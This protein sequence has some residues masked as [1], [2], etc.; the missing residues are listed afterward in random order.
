MKIRGRWLILTGVMAAV[1]IFAAFGLNR[2]TQAQHF[3]AKVERGE[4]DDVVEATGTINA[5]ITV[6]VGSQVS[7]S[8]AKLNADFNS[9][10]RKGDVVALIDPALFKG[11]LLQ[12]TADLENAKANLVAARANLEKAKAG[13]VQTKADY[14]RAVRLTRDGVMSEQ[15]LDLAKSNYDSASASVGA[16]AANVTQAQAQI[17][18]K[19]AAVAVA[20]TNLDYTVIRSPIDGT[21]VARNVDVGQTVAASL[22][23]PTIFTIAQ[24]LT[25]MWVYAKT[26]ESDVGNIKIGKPVTFKVDAF[27]KD[28]FHGVVSQVRMNPTT[29]QSVVTY[30]TIIEFLNPELKLFPGM[31][32]Y[33]TIPVDTVKNALKLPNTALRYKPPM[34]AEEILSIYKQYGIDGSEQK[35]VVGEPAAGGVLAG[36]GGQAA[37][38]NPPRVP[39]KDSAVVWKL[40]ADNTMEPVKVS[41]GITDHAYTEVSGVLKGA[42]QEGDD[43][44]IRS[45]APKSQGLGGIRR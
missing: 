44:V 36:N 28:T 8:I 16:A 4:I 14:D 32:A 13:M 19:D 17:S 22:Q 6:Q 42:L 41:L 21:V 34:P 33:V 7:G 20:Q 15:Q 3:A 9:R 29:V 27:P 43:V 12:A 45:M 1:G 18:Q 30:D 40:R 37:A 39:K 38:Q 2:N 5:V 31:T 25:K 11:A 26:D 35:Q 23:A 24:D 10:V